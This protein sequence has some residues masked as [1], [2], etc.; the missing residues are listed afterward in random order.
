MFVVHVLIKV[1]IAEFP[2][3]RNG[4]NPNHMQELADIWNIDYNKVPH[5]V[6]SHRFP[7]IYIDDN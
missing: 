3:F 5:W 4:S 6:W 1:D 2:G 7:G